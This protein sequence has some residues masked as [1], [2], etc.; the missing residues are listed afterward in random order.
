MDFA[1]ENLV[2]RAKDNRRAEDERRG[3]LGLEERA[4]FVG[5]PVGFVFLKM[6]VSALVNVHFNPW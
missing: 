1:T 5:D 4:N 2:L 3:D 6:M